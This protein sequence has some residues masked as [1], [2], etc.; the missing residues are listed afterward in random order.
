MAFVTQRFL[1][2]SGSLFFL[3]WG[4]LL[5]PPPPVMVSPRVPCFSHMS[6]STYISCFLGLHLYSWHFYD[7]IA[8]ILS[9][10]LLESE[11]LTSN[12]HFTVRCLHLD[13]VHVFQTQYSKTQS[14][15]SLPH[16]YGIQYLL[17]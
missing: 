4:L 16:S 1:H 12:S 10:N 11:P 7:D 6:N 2:F 3:L 9:H 14:L 13:V 15:P 5:C 8:L 17:R